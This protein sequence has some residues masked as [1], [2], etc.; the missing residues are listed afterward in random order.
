LTPTGATE[1][2][3]VTF[4]LVRTGTAVVTVDTI[5]TVLSLVTDTVEFLIATETGLL[6]AT[7]TGLLAVIGAMI[8]TGGVVMI[9]TTGDD[10]KGTPL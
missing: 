10:T 8:L 1:I 5:D 7:E 3:A 2:F 9:L 4:L 6:M